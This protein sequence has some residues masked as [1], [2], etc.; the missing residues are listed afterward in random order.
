MVL[1]VLTEA[2]S[3]F[4]ALSAATLALGW[5]FA[6][7]GAAWLNRAIRPSELR[8]A[9]LARTDGLTVVLLAPAVA[10]AS[11]SGFLAIYGWPNS[12]DSMNYHL[13]R[14][15]HW[16]Q[17]GGVT[18]F[19][20]HITHQLYYPPW[21]EY[22]ALHL[23]LLG[24]EERWANQVQWL[25]ALGCLVGI[26]LLARELGGG[27]RAQACAAL[28][29]ATLPIGILEAS[30]TLIDYTVA[31]WLVCQTVALLRWRARPSSLAAG[32]EVGAALGLALLTKGTSYLFAPPLIVALAPWRSIRGPALKPALA[33]GLLALLL[34]APHYARNLETFGGPLGPSAPGR[35]Q[36]LDDQQQLLSA[37][38]GPEVL[39]FNLVWNVG[40]HLGTPSAAI[41]GGLERALAAITRRLGAD[42][43]DPSLSA[44]GKPV[45]IGLPVPD[46][47][48][49]GNL[50]QAL[51]IGAL[52]PVVT[53]RAWTSGRRDVVLL[54]AALLAGF[55]LFSALL[56]WQ[57]H[58][59]RLELPLF[60]LWAP[61]VALALERHRR[62]LI[63][64]ALAM[65]VWAW[66]FL[67]LNVSHPLLGERTV[68]NLSR[69]EQYFQQAPVKLAPFTGAVEQVRLTGCVQVG[70]L[71]NWYDW[72][73]PF[74]ALLPEVRAPGGRWEHVG[75]ANT[76]RRLLG[77]RPPFEPCA[78]IELNGRQPRSHSLE[79]RAFQRSWAQ[80]EVAVYLPRR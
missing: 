47:D 7:A 23:L 58:H 22:A 37:R 78:L 73:Y 40:L 13:S 8:R 10:I 74:W 31:L 12:W 50:V 35:G 34:N 32:L 51:L 41:N 76:T 61:L 6:L 79:G 33:C 9:S 2:L 72:E 5:A 70:L 16:E 71:L 26:S 49:A 18:F 55:L 80:G 56:R 19:P 43:A 54:A 66:P 25:S 17:N 45:R 77:R 38:F 30:S 27:P 15:L 20:T 11:I 64:A 4:E 42:P 75:V 46:E 3:L 60:V 67:V 57:P 65:V 29:C 21:A 1:T 68:F 62:A 39:A 59:S 69:T 63:A 14:V 52:L 44:L 28:F 36:T 53:R 24:G 48:T